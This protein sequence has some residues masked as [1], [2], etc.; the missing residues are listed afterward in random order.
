EAGERRAAF[1]RLP[2]HQLALQRSAQRT[3]RR[4]HVDRFEKVALPLGVVAVEDCD[5]RAEIQPESDVVSEIREGELT[6]MHR[7]RA[8]KKYSK[9]DAYNPAV[10]C[11]CSYNWPVLAGW[12]ACQPDGVA[13]S[14]QRAADR[15]N[16]APTRSIVAT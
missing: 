12:L 8:A 14:E 6:K 1:D 13:G 16:N 10:R 5:A 4:E 7:C 3:C 11:S 2:V 15:R 9:V